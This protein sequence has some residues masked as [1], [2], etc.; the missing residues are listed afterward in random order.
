MHKLKV[1]SSLAVMSVVK[2][3]LRPNGTSMALSPMQVSECPALTG[4]R[5]RQ[6]CHSKVLQDVYDAVYSSSC[7]ASDPDSHSAET[8]QPRLKDT[9]RV[10]H[11]GKTEISL[12][13]CH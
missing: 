2:K 6:T 4:C 1:Y 8:Q 11:A 12:K 9:L 10:W 3:Y 13:G 5:F 7:C